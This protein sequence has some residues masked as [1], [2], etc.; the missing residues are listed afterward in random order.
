MVFSCGS[1][2][3]EVGQFKQQ[4]TNKPEC[5]QQCGSEQHKADEAAEL[6][7]QPQA[8]RHCAHHLKKKHRHTPETDQR[9]QER[10]SCTQAKHPVLQKTRALKSAQALTVTYTSIQNS[11]SVLYFKLDTRLFIDSSS[12]QN[13]HTETK[14]GLF[15][16]IFNSSIHSE[17]VLYFKLK[18][19]CL[20][21]CN[22]EYLD[23]RR[24]ERNPSTL[25][26]SHPSS[27]TGEV[28]L[29]GTILRC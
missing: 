19:A 4:S 29:K 2:D 3:S 1:T 22:Y 21:R 28:L 18:C 11:S 23:T 27:Q 14:R 17:C 20:E 12:S 26:L 9:R 13:K 8:K 16:Y 5:P 7:D 6:N 10:T 25:S 24:E 15:I